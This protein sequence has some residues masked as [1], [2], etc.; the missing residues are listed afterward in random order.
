M[1]LRYLL[2]LF[3]AGL[4]TWH[5]SAQNSMSG[6]ALSKPRVAYQQDWDFY[7]TQV[8]DS[9]SF[10]FDEH[11][12]LTQQ[13]DLLGVGGRRL[14]EGTLHVPNPV[15]EKPAGLRVRLRA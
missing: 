9:L 6:R 10:V 3:T 5:A 8:E 7:F 1:A 4:I 15:N 12:A 2:L 13:R 14:R 11:S